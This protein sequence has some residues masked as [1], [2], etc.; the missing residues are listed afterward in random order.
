MIG[1]ARHGAGRRLS[2]TRIASSGDS[3]VPWLARFRVG[4]VRLER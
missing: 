3:I 2:K 1:A 4:D